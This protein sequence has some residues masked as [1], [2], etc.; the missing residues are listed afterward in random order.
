MGVNMKHFLSGFFAGF[1]Y[2]NV[3]CVFDLLKVRAQETKSHNMSYRKEILRIFKQDGI[4]GF[5]KGY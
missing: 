2:S 5:S 1:V 3:A 4:K